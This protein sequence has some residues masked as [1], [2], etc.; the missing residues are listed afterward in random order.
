MNDF[1]QRR[2]PQQ[3]RS[4]DRVARLLDAASQLVVSGGVDALSTRAIAAAAAVP[5]ASLYQYFADKDD[6]LLALVERDIEEMDARVATG[7]AALD[8]PSWSHWSRPPWPPSSRSTA[9]ARPS[10]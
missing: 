5:V 8:R 3:S 10:S 1:R 2:V 9:S 6:I 4:R 7:I